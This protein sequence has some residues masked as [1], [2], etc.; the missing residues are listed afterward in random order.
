MTQILCLSV[1]KMASCAANCRG[2]NVVLNSSIA[3]RK[4]VKSLTLQFQN[5]KLQMN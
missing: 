3:K 4:K 5:T 1:R 2:A